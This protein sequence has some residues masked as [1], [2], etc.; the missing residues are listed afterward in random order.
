MGPLF[1]VLYINDIT[2]VITC[3]EAIFYADDTV[4]YTH[5][6]TIKYDAERIIQRDLTELDN[7]CIHNK[8]TINVSKTKCMLI[9]TRN[10]T[11]TIKPTI[12]LHNT[13]LDVVESYK[14]LAWT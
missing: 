8:L 1:F 10:A 11:V 3:S 5:A 2:N 14:Y 7:W 13:K 6:K 12:T 9:T 4:L